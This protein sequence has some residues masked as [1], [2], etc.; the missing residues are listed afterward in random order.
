MLAGFFIHAFFYRRNKKARSIVG[1]A[2]R[3]YGLH[4]RLAA[5]YHTQQSPEEPRALNH[6]NLHT[7]PPF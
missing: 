6:D 2:I 3:G 1:R 7:L 4:C 5:K